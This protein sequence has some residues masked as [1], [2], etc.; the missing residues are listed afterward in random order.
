MSSLSAPPPALARRSRFTRA[1]PEPMRLT[2]DD[3][4]IV[5]HIA[6]HRF[7][8]STHLVRLMPHRSDKKLLERLAALY[9]NGIIDRPRAQL[10]YYATAGSAP[11]VYALGNRGAL[12]LAEHDGLDR[13]HVDWTWKNRSVGRLFIEHTLLT[14]DVMVA[15]ECATR[16]RPDL[17]LMDARQMLAVAPESTRSAANPL[18]LKTRVSHDGKLIDVSVVPDAVFGL[19]FTAE[20]KRKYF[21][22]E[23]DRATMPIMRTD[24]HQTSYHRKLLGYLAGGGK[25]NA[26]GAHFGIGNFRVLTV[27]TSR[28]R[29]ATMIEALR[30]LTQGVGSQQFLFV[31]RATLRA[32]LDLFSVKW[33]T[34]KGDHVSLAD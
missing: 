20:R 3:L 29:T 27:T 17:K 13:A 21:F 31:D 9:H 25:G 24:P 32:S 18:R 26:F 28:E 10:D 2:D 12:I 5:R 4:A 8:R 11:M 22:L 6:K 30:Q 14:A 1:T 16:A 19:D 23:A 34:G 15:A 33:T 7:L